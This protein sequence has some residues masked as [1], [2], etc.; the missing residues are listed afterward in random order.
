MR[1]ILA[2]PAASALRAVP[3]AGKLMRHVVSGA[4]IVALGAAL[5]SGTALADNWTTVRIGGTGN[6][7]SI[8]PHPKVQNLYF[9]TTD[10]G[11]PYRWNHTAQRWEGLL[12]HVPATDWNWAAC[13]N[14]AVDPNDSTGNILYATV[15][16]YADYTFSWAGMG[17]V[18][19]STDRGTTW[20]DAG[21]P[22]RVSANGT[23]KSGGDRIGVDPQNSTVVYVTSHADGTWRGT[24]SG[25]TWAQIN[26]LNGRFVAFDVSGGM[27]SGVTRNVFLGCSD[28]VYQSTDG[29][30]SFALM[31]GSPSGS[32]RAA[33]HSNGTLYVAASSGL[34][35]YVGGTWSNISPTSGGYHGLDVNPANSNE[36]I[37]S[38]DSWDSPTYRSNN[39]GASWTQFSRSWNVTEV[40][41]VTPDHYG[42]GIND[43]AWDPFDPNQVW[44]VDI[45][46]VFQTTNVW[47]SQVLWKARLVG[48]E[49]FVTTGAMIAPPPGGPNLLLSSGAD[50]GGF[51]HKSL[52]DPPHQ[53]MTFYFPWTRQGQ[54]GNMTGVAIQQTNPNFIVRVGRRGWD[55]PA[56]A[57]YSTDGG[58][59]Y[60]IF[61][62]YPTGE[63]G[64]RVAVAATN[65]TIIWAAQGGS[66]Y[67][68]TNRGA[69][70]TKI[71]SLPTGLVPGTNIF[72]GGYPNPLAAD[73]VNGNKFYVYHAGNFY[74]STDGGS[75]FSVT[76]SNLPNISSNSLLQVV[77]SPG[78]EG[79]V[80]VSLQGSGL[81]H[82]TDSGVSFTKINNV[83]NARL[84]SVG[85]AATIT[86]AV[87]VM[88]TVNN[89]VD[90]I[91]RSDD[92]GATWTRMDTPAYRMGND[93][94]TMAA[95]QGIYGR[96]FIGTNGNGIF[97]SGDPNAGPPPPPPCSTATMHVASVDAFASSRNCAH[98][99]AT[100]VIKD[101]C[102]DGVGGATVT[103][104]F[105]GSSTQTVSGVTDSNGS[106]RLDGTGC[107][108]NISVTAC[109]TNVTLPGL[110]YN[111]AENVMTCDSN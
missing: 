40:P 105:T 43:F 86:P 11:N 88:G 7:T 70:W 75:T 81:Y 36:V 107:N 110:T 79:D 2:M 102:G 3:T 31:S 67:R 66:T 82:S 23:D 59:S 98:P 80:W 8:K 13:G 87:Y 91:F 77:T 32:K 60:T 65:E 48:F 6:I 5:V 58:T 15:G 27:V 72:D 97:V 21:L 52:V 44:F 108:S 55:G 29:G 18:I 96:V 99:V 42:K 69:A 93:P 92:N 45:F 62:K 111:S 106:V 95:D 57:G 41:Y 50:L 54:S 78:L 94:N 104:Q 100:V 4:R 84:M 35:K 39:A 22:I 34:Y 19:K 47:A 76:V 9:A 74:V 46:N 16:K 109:V 10:V 14:I 1:N 73:K 49:E 25:T 17:K 26:T 12:N 64:G 71:T 90:G 38:V 83:Q 28:G 30:N 33:I 20:T 63:S 101:F 85:K 68:S 24:N 103:V 89:I 53:D 37:A 61:S 56:Y 51:D